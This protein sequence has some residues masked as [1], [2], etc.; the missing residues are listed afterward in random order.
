VVVVVVVVVV[1]WQPD[2][3]HKQL[4]DVSYDTHTKLSLQG[5]EAQKLSL[6]VV[7]YMI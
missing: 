7:D 2:E 4:Y 5:F 6:V 3:I 1:G